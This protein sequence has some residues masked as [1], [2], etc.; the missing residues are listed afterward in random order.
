MPQPVAT[1]GEGF[2]S[3]AFIV[4]DLEAAIGRAQA[5]GLHLVERSDRH[6][7]FA[8]SDFLGFE[9]RLVEH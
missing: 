2:G 7:G 5:D 9:L 8:Y 1:H 6:A 3:L 4:R